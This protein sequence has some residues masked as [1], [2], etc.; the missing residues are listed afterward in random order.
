MI[1]QVMTDLEAVEFMHSIAPYEAEHLPTPWHGSRI[2][3]DGLLVII[4][5]WGYLREKMLVSIFTKEEYE[6]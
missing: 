2:R 1:S 6:A 4:E 5:E 3:I